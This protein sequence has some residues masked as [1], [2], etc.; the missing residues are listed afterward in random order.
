MLLTAKFVSGPGEQVVENMEGPLVF[1]LSYGTRLLQQVCSL[2]QGCFFRVWGGKK[3]V[4][5][6]PAAVFI[7]EIATR[8]Q[9]V[10]KEN[11]F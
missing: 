9:Q 5:L 8:D 1:G 10:N 7:L 11:T 4:L 3:K 6:I 2:C